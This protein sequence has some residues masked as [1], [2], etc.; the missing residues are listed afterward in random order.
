MLEAKCKCMVLMRGLEVQCW[1]RCLVNAG[2]SKATAISLED[3]QVGVHT[4]LSPE[5]QHD[6]GPTSWEGSVTSQL[7]LW[8]L[9]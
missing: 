4:P 2:L 3:V 7:G 8:L 9:N 5:D 6:R 1:E